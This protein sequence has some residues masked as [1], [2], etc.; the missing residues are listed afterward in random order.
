MLNLDFRRL[1]LRYF[2]KKKWNLAWF[3]KVFEG[4][5]SVSFRFIFLLQIFSEITFVREISP[6]SSGGLGYYRHEWVK[7]PYQ[8]GGTCSIFQWTPSIWIE[9]LIVAERQGRNCQISDLQPSI[10]HVTASEISTASCVDL[11]I[12]GVLDQ[13]SL[14]LRY[15]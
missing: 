9:R 2:W 15:F 8:Y 11:F 10:A 6:K 12:P 13:G 1:Q 5:L 14:E 4:E 7:P 3:W